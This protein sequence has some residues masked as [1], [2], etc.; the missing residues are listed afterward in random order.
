EVE[1]TCDNVIIIHRGKVAVSCTLADLKARAGAR[2]HLMM[3]V[4]G[5]GDPNIFRSVPGVLDLHI[6]GNPLADTVDLRITTNDMHQL[7]PQLSQF[8][9]D[10][11]WR[12]LELRV[13]RPTLEDL[14]VQITE[15]EDVVAV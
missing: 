11:E 12:L 9:T 2:A 1:A 5:L 14:F 15:E 4:N 3:T 6:G 13:E 7:A 8:A 10:H